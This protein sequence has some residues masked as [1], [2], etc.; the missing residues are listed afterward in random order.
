[1]VK[2]MQFSGILVELFTFQSHCAPP[3]PGAIEDGAMGWGSGMHPPSCL[4]TVLG[5][6]INNTNPTFISVEGCIKAH[7][8]AYAV[9]RPAP[10]LL[11]VEGGAE[12]P[13][14]GLCLNFDANLS[15]V[16]Y[17]A[18]MLPEILGERAFALWLTICRLM[19]LNMARCKIVDRPAPTHDCPESL[20]AGPRGLIGGDCQGRQGCLDVG[21]STKRYV[22]MPRS[23]DLVYHLSRCPAALSQYWG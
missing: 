2:S 10:E 9:V 18:H 17:C 23:L 20:T 6:K 19:H 11:G 16:L 4:V 21:Y 3:V 13:H 12:S 8:V 15:S 5:T 1:M 22:P 7:R 14:Y